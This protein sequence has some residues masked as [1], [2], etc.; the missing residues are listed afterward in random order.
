M[1]RNEGSE[2]EREREGGKEGGRENL[3]AKYEGRREQN[4]D[5]RGATLVGGR[6]LISVLNAKQKLQVKRAGK[7]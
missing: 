6:R 2:R 5:K 3:D 1:L 4:R 7:R